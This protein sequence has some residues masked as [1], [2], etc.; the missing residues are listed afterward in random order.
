M[1]G[2]KRA[3][4]P[5]VRRQNM[6]ILSKAVQFS[7][8]GRSWAAATTEGLLIY[9]LDETLMFD[10]FDLDEDITPATIQRVLGRH[11]FAKVRTEHNSRDINIYINIY[12]YIYV[13]RDDVKNRIG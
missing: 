4:D 6:A 3:I 8:T 9:S 11:E 12:I 7:P 1:I 13:D 10:P 2:A 5:G